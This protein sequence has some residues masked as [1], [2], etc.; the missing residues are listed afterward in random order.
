MLTDARHSPIAQTIQQT[1]RE[2]ANRA[3]LAM[4]CAVADYGACTVIDVEY[5]RKGKVN[6]A[7]AQL[8]RHR[9]TAGPS[10]STGAGLI[11]V[12]QLAN[13]AH[14]RQ[15]RE[16]LAESLDSP[17]LMIHRYQ[18]SRLA[19]SMNLIAQ[20]AQL[21]AVAEVRCEQDDPADQGMKQTL[22][23]GSA[24]FQTAHGD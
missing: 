9:Q 8:D 11:A 18:Q 19:Q 24:E 17:T 2:I 10:E 14:R 6:I 16:A 12:P 7:A 3:R 4:K 5:G 21:R 15:V 1:S 23:I 20:P 22:A 13:A